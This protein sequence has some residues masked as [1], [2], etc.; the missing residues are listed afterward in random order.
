MP[1][2]LLAIGLIAGGIALYRFFLKASPA[3][4]KAALL[5]IAALAVG[6]AALFLAVTGRLPAAIAILVALWP[7]GVS[8]LKQRKAAATR[9]NPPEE[10]NLTVREAYEVLGLPDNAGE[11]DIRAAHVRLMKKLH[12]DQEGSDWL[13]KKINAAKDLL[14]K[15]RV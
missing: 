13:A 2:L 10:P 12:P 5:A 7:L 6:L 14:L 1:Y 4:V 15:S 9:S 8:W 3:Q 11:D